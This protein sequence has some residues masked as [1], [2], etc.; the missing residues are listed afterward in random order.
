MDELTL[1]VSNVGF[2]IVACYFMYKQN[3]KMSDSLTELSK[4]L[5]GVKDE[6]ISLKLKIEK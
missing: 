1:F 4:T 3:V 5:Q 2:P 6:L